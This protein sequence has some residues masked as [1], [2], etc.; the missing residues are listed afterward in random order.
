MKQFKNLSRLI[1]VFVLLII[2]TS[3]SY[4][5]QAEIAE[6]NVP[7]HI[8]FFL[9]IAIGVGILIAIL[10]TIKTFRHNKVE[11]TKDNDW[12]DQRIEKK[13]RRVEYNDKLL[14]KVNDLEEEIEELSGRKINQK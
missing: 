7:T 13:A 11:H 4:S 9:A 2:L 12:E 14:Q 8:L 5:E 10:Y 1:A 3:C 6:T